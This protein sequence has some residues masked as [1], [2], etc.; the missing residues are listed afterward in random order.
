MKASITPGPLLLIQ[1][2]FIDPDIDN[3]PF[4]AIAVSHY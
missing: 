3:L 4:S 2:L 1:L